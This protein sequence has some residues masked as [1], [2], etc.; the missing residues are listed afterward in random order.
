M[1]RGKVQIKRIEKPTKRQVTFA[2]RRNGVLKKAHELSVLCD[3]QIA[4]IIFSD[5]GR[6]YEFSSSNLQEMMQKYHKHAKDVQISKLEVQKYMEGLKGDSDS[7]IS[8]I[9]FLQLYDRKLVGDDLNSCSY[10]ELDEIQKQ[11]EKSLR[12]IRERKDQLL[13][14]YV[15][16]LRAKEKYLLHESAK[17]SA[18]KHKEVTGSL[19]SE[20]ETG[21]CIGL[22]QV[23]Y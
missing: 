16:N 4:V 5:T 20:V 9:Q 7:M 14:E 8:E 21:L 22:P 6:L 1:M 19:G 23:R 2:K 13:A 11:M 18:D 10:D 17:P 12:T 3:A 15:E